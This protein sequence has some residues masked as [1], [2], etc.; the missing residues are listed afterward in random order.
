MGKTCLFNVMKTDVG[1]IKMGS[2]SMSLETTFLSNGNKYEFKKIVESSHE[3]N[4]NNKFTSR[5]WNV[6]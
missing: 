5:F 6:K 2:M 3:K 4:K 1:H